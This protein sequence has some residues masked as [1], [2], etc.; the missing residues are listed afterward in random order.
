MLK[1][2][3]NLEDVRTAPMLEWLE[4]KREIVSPSGKFMKNVIKEDFRIR[5][6]GVLSGFQVVKLFGEIDESGKRNRGIE[7]RDGFTKDSSSGLE[8]G[9]IFS[10]RIR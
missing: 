3:K 7:K 4:D 10:F 2:D 1:P 9:C 5:I 6:G 8:G